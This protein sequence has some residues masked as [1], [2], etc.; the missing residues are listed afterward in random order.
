MSNSLPAAAALRT[1]TAPS[2]FFSCCCCCCCCC[3]CLPA[4][5]AT[6]PHT[7]SGVAG[8]GQ[9]GRHVDP[10]APAAGRFVRASGRVDRLLELQ[11]RRSQPRSCDGDWSG[12]LVEAKQI[13]LLGQTSS[14][15]TDTDT[16][17]VH[18]GIGAAASLSP[19]AARAAGPDPLRRLPPAQQLSSVGRRRR[20]PP[21]LLASLSR[22]PPM[23]VPRSAD[24][25][26]PADAGRVADWCRRAPPIIAARAASSLWRW[27]AA[28]A[29]GLAA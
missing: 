9:H 10:A 6:Q 27:T 23:P 1:T 18:V 13:I 26:P 20:L 14:C 7:Y 24:D 25:R 21:A 4:G 16:Y 22:L 12:Y 3:C 5:A 15:S 28:R 8:R 19:T 2:P 11:C 29:A 17:Y